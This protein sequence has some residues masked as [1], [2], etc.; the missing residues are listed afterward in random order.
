MGNDGIIAS[1]D[2]FLNTKFNVLYMNFNY[3]T[4]QTPCIGKEYMY[5]RYS[6]AVYA[7]WQ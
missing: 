6:S 1:L 7:N 4:L 2:P 5:N 3:S